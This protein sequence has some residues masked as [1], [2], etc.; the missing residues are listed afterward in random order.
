MSSRDAIEAKTPILPVTETTLTRRHRPGDQGSPPDIQT[1]QTSR[2]RTRRYR[3]RKLLGI[4]LV[5]VQVDKKMVQWLVNNGWLLS[6]DINDQKEIR[7]A[8]DHFL[9]SLPRSKGKP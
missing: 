6:A 5:R 2:D 7:R 8:L 1:C 9:Y 4:R 3:E